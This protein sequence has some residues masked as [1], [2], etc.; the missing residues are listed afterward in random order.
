MR[1]QTLLEYDGQQY[2]LRYTNDDIFAYDT[3][4][5]KHEYDDKFDKD[6]NRKAVEQCQAY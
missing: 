1:F 5:Y 3:R 6:G 4:A 2:Y